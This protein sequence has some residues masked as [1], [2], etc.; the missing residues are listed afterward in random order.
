MHTLFDSLEFRVLRDRLFETLESEEEI[1]DSGFDLDAHPARSRASVGRLAG[2]ARARAAAAVGRARSQGTW[3]A[4]TGDVLALAL[5]AGDGAAAWLD[6]GAD[7]AR[8]TTPRSPPGS[9]DPRVPKV[10]HDAKGPMLALAARGWPL[11]G[12]E[13]DTALVGLPRPPDQR[14]YDLADLTLRYLK[15]ELKAEDADDD[16]QLSLR[17]RS[18]TTATPAADAAMLHA[19]AVLDLAEALD[20]ELEAARRHPAAAPTSSCR[21]S[22]ARRDGADRHRRR[23]RPP[24]GARGALRRRGEA[25]PPTRRSRVI[26]KEI[27]LGSPKQL[28]VV[29]FDELGMPKTKRTKTGYTTDADALQAL[30]AKTA[31]PFLL[32]LLRHRDVARLRQTVEGLL[33]TVADRRAHP[34]HL[35]PD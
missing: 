35:Q 34:H 29:L 9:A 22:S 6:V 4:G 18:T 7:H 17:R 15:R 10:L 24:R 32:A 31:H 26:G 13:R 21:W 14:S 23:H 20:A 28:Q 3:R 2:R 27:N 30:Y 19:R 1:D 33:K 11:A 12:L 16:G 5:A 25:T 8:R